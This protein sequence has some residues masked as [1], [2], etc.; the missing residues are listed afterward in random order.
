MDDQEK[1]VDALKEALAQTL[2]DIRVHQ[3]LEETFVRRLRANGVTW[4]DIADIYGVSRQAAHARW[5][6]REKE[7]QL[8]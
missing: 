2:G 5:S 4:A 8:T 1:L 7:W 3:K 6:G